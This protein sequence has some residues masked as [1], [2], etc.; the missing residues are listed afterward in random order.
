MT[1]STPSIKE[2]I[3]SVSKHKNSNTSQDDHKSA[4][5]GSN[6]SGGAP[7]GGGTMGK[8]KVKGQ[9]ERKLSLLSGIALI[10]GTMIGSGIFVS[11]TGLLER[12]G[13]IHLS[14]V[15]WGLCGVISMLGALAYAELGTMIPSS[16]AEYSYFM[17]AFGAFPAYTFSWVC[18][19]IIKPS[20]LAIVCLSFAEY[21]VESFTDECAP[22]PIAIKV[23]C[24][25]CIAVVTFINCV[26][27]RLAT[28]VQ[29]AFFFGKLLAIAIIICV[30]FYTLINGGAEG[31]LDDS[32]AKPASIGA[33]TTAFY[34]GLWAYDGWNNLNY[35][36]EEIINPSR[37][38]PLSVIIGIPLVTVCYLL[39]N[40]SYLLVMSPNEMMIS[41]AVAVTFGSRTLGMFYWLM[42]LSVAVSTFGTANGTIFAAGRL[43]YVASREGHLM[44]VLSFVHKEKLTPAP[45]LLLNGVIAAIMVLMGGI[46]SLI[47]FFSFTVSFFYALAMVALLVLRRT[48]PNLAR[49]YKVPIIVP[50]IVLV[51]SILL[52]VCPIIDNPKVEYIYSILFTVGGAL[53]YVPFVRY[54]IQVPLLSKMTQ[55]LQMILKCTPVA[56]MPD[57]PE[58]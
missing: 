40:I 1:N 27:V 43:C 21:V 44:N 6:T 14:L 41:D 51:A 47:D 42:P 58:C 22:T 23:V 37:N 5:S 30:G 10:V 16:G 17:V 49:P 39:V 26:S 54:N 12:T 8:E 55:F 35:V 53:T 28:M 25:T 45:A 7:G 36:T 29:N 50:I 38:L 11:P 56:A 48:R 4:N 33:I 46:E 31:F 32:Q 18:T 19:I 57:W 20:Q 52:M 3:F 13:S 2:R 34:S 15:V 24:L 9:M